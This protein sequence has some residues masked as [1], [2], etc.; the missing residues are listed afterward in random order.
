VCS[1]LESLAMI[2]CIHSLYW[3]YKFVVSRLSMLFN[4]CLHDL[5][6]ESGI[7]G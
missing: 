4:F 3:D 7:S 5:C 6:D 1:D 2:I